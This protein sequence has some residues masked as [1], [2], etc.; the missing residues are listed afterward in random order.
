MFF[1]SP[2]SDVEVDTW[3]IKFEDTVLEAVSK[4]MQAQDADEVEDD[5]EEMHVSAANSIDAARAAELVAKQDSEIAEEE[6]EEQE[7]DEEPAG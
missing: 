1:F 4:E 6:L 5:R 3:L 7:K 2:D